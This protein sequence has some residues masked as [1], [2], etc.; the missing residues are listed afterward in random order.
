MKKTLGHVFERFLY[1]VK[2]QRAADVYITVI[3]MRYILH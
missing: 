3:H 2:D 1:V